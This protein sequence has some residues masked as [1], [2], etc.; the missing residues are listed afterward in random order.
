MNYIMCPFFRT[1]CLRFDC[2]AFRSRRYFIHNGRK[3]D[4][5]E[6]RSDEYVL[7]RGWFIE[8]FCD[9]LNKELPRKRLKIQRP[10]GHPTEMCDLS[11]AG[12]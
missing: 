2:V 10:E 7:E 9:A 6:D 11:D 3:Y 4:I 8:P 12:G 1:E 5:R